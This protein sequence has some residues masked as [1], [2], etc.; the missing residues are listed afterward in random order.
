MILYTRR[1]EI[2]SFVREDWRG[3]VRI[4]RDFQQSEYRYFDREMPTQKE[5]AQAAAAY[6]ASTGLWFSVFEPGGEE[7]LGYVC[8]HLE[9]GGLDLGY[10]FHSSAHGKGY[11]FESISAL[12]ELLGQVGIAEKF[13]A[14]TALQNTP[15]VQLLYRLG[16]VKVGEEEVC[17]YEG[18]PFLGGMFEKRLQKADHGVK[19]MSPRKIDQN[20]ELI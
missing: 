7:M 2:R 11:A 15:S 1:L 4:A 3:L 10:G 17:F 14:G 19:P 5:Q 12:M 8:F 6:C 20:A 16:F 13:T 9:N 18:H